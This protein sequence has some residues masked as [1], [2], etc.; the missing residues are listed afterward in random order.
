MSKKNSAK[1]SV[2]VKVFWLLPLLLVFLQFLMTGKSM[3]QIRYEELAEAVRNPFWLQKGFVYDG[4]STNIGW[5]G[6]LA[7]VYNFFGFGLFWAK[8]LRLFLS[9]IS[10]FCIAALLKKYLGEKKALVP[11]L[12]IG[13]SPTLLYLNT[14]QTT[15]GLDLVYFPIILYLIL[16]LDF[17]QKGLFWAKQILAWFLAMVAWLS[18]PSFLVY[19]PFLGVIYVFQLL[20]INKGSNFLVRNIFVSVL[21]F[22]I[23]LILGFLIVQNKSVLLNDTQTKSGLFRAGGKTQISLV[24]LWTGLGVTAG[25]LF[26]VG[27]SYYFELKGVE[28]GD[29]YPIAAVLGV[30]FIS[31]LTYLKRP[32]LRLVILLGIGGVILGTIFLHIGSDGEL[33][34]LRRSGGILAAFYT[35]FTVS[36]IVIYDLGKKYQVVKWMLLAVLLVLPLH[37]LL[38]FPQNLVHITDLSSYRDNTW[39]AIAETPQKSLK[40]LVDSVGRE[41]LKLACKDEKGNVGECRYSEVFAAVEGS[42]VWNSLY[43]KKVLGF[44]SKTKQLI[45]LNV[46]LWNTYYFGH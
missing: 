4:I 41:D 9:L 32:K 24:N 19:L 22:L 10:L 35:L 6:L 13:L 39:F 15:Y 30:I 18:Y 43:C 31:V 11:L 25:D 14:F 2:L 29:V 46:D 38:V 37:H 21:A 34:G 23:P 27:N 33:A 7:L 8:Y 3:G 26:T 42:C 17:G 28:F 5:Y 1:E 16:T 36:W 20:K 44:D 40:I 12:T 45:P